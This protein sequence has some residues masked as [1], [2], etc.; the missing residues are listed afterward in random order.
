MR[1][2]GL[3]L[4][5]PGG[6][7][8][9]VDVLISTTSD[10]RVVA[11]ADLTS[12]DPAEAIAHARA[13]GAAL[14]W[15]HGGRELE[16]HGFRPAGAYRRLHADAVPPGSELPRSTSPDELFR[17]FDD[18]YRGLWGHKLVLRERFDALAARDDLVHVVLGEIGVCRV[19]LE[20]RLIDGPGV[21]PG[22]RDPASY[23]RLLL[24]ACS[25]LG[26]G[27]GTLDSW[28]DAPEVID[29]YH[30]LGFETVEEVQGYEL[31]L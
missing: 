15:A 22:A 18:G 21:V 2:C 25:V 9:A 14:V 23:A 1:R 27:P 12:G 4:G 7:V 26:E 19:E 3:G 29:A 20:D 17:L 5:S 31:E 16:R 10:G 30:A 6:Y 8:P 11:E 13:G 24:G 28:G